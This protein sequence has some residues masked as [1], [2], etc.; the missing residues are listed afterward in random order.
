MKMIQTAFQDDKNI[1]LPRCFYEVTN[2]EIENDPK[3]S[4][5]SRSDKKLHLNFYRVD[6]FQEVLQLEPQ[7]PYKLKEPE[8]ISPEKDVFNNDGLDLII[9][10]AVAFSISTDIAKDSA[11]TINDKKVGKRGIKRLGH[12]AGFYDEYFKRHERYTSYNEK[13]SVYL[14]GLGMEEQLVDDLPV[15]GMDVLLDGLLVNGSF[16]SFE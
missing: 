13:R 7:G 5:F 15:D 10:P 8:S 12:G 2:P 4:N 16:Y 11:R 3:Y 14:L 6:T 9:V 1:Y